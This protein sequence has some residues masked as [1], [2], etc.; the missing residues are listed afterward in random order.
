MKGKRAENVKQKKSIEENMDFD[1]SNS[2][3]SGSDTV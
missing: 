1:G 2:K 3:V